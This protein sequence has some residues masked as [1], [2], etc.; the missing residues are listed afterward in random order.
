MSITRLEKLLN[1]DSGNRLNKIIQRAQKIDSLTTT[2]KSTLPMEFAEN[3]LS[4]NLH[5]NGELVLVCSSSAWASRLRFESNA[6]LS[7]A[8]KAGVEARICKVTVGRY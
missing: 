5:D 1:S 3:L 7:A 2:L 8:Q 4:A 6:L